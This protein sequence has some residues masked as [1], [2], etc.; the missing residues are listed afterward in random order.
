MTTARGRGSGATV[1]GARVVSVNVGLPGPLAHGKGEVRS[2]IFKTSVRGAVRFRENGLRGDGQA[3]KKNHGGPDKAAC[4]YPLE[5]Y[6]YWEGRLGPGLEPG[7]FGEN[8]S[9]EGLVETEVGIGD[10]FRVGMAVA[11]VS[12]PRVPCFKLAARHGEEMLA[13]WVKET[14]FTGFYL[15][16]LEPGEVRAGDDISL[17]ESGGSGFTVAGANRVMHGDADVAG[18]ERLRAVP[19]LSA[20]WKR[21]LSCRLEK[22][23]SEQ[24]NEPRG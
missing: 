9:A 19:E 23:A 21:M 4:V 22:L 16:C 10:V 1:V 2:G 18:I 15:R 3:D 5:H 24:R 12:Q 13:A 17:V 20:E 8:F 14:G 7:A 6:P 11:Q